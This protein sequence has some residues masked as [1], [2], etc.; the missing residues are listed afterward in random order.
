VNAAFPEDV[1]VVVVA[2]N[3]C[4]HL[5]IT[6][7]SLTDAGC[8]AS[9]I[10]VVDVASADG[11]ADLVRSRWP[12][13]R[14]VRLPANEGPNPAR[15][16]G[17]LGAD[18]PFVLLM[19]PDVAVERDAVSLLRAAM[20]EDPAVAA[21]SPLVVY[22][23][24]PDIIQYGE[25]GLHFIC[26][27]VNRWQGRTVSERGDE[28]RD[29]GCASGCALLISREA[30]VRVGLFDERYFL[31]KDDGDFTHR[32]RLAGY[33][34]VEVPRARVHHHE[35]PRGRHLFH[36]QIRNR[37]HV[38]LKTYQGRTLILLFPVLLAH[39]VLQFGLLAIKGSAADYLKAVAGLARMLPRL[40]SDRARV[41]RLRARRDRDLLLCDPLVVRS[42]MMGGP[43]LRKGKDLY[44][45]ALR[46]YWR[47]LLRS[48]LR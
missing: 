21:A 6:F 15:N 14:I 47:L 16:A 36:Y 27:A 25:T 28:P 7:G 8:R 12:E 39:E 34:I 13:A 43:L 3:A 23:D 35:R 41:A 9:R 24:R 46:A 29:V 2:H 44:D 22:A 45:R 32:I 42:D 10:T 20:D 19:D 48:V 18:T 17:I 1:S 30:A 38:M 11:T 4:S 40:P 33:R 31:G 37:W 5:P 26:E